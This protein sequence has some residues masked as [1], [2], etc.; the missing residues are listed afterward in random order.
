M[1]LA[2]AHADG[3]ISSLG[4]HPDLPTASGMFRQLAAT[5]ALS[6]TWA[7]LAFRVAAAS[8]GIVVGA[9]DTTFTLDPLIAAL[10]DVTYATPVS[11]GSWA[12][13]TLAPPG[14]FASMSLARILN[15]TSVDGR[16][17]VVHGYWAVF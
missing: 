7:P 14:N 1:M 12:I 6:N 5:L 10:N 13:P 4:V 2:S 17:S 15:S 11:D 8:A 16:Y 3:L 9:M